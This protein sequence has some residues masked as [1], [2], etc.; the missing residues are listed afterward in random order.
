M[1]QEVFSK[2]GKQFVPLT[3]CTKD[4]IQAENI[5][6]YIILLIGVITVLFIT[7]CHT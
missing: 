6:S 7:L 4:T 3:K 1:F 5:I 2:I